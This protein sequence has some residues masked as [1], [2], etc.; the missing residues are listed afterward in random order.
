LAV[1]RVS[2]AVAIFDDSTNSINVT[3]SPVATM[4]QG[5]ISETGIS[6]EQDALVIDAL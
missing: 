5:V 1:S 2:T 4:V 3:L 6:D